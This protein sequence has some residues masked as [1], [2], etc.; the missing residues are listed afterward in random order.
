V[1]GL[2][3]IGVKPTNLAFGLEARRETYGITAGELASYNNGMQGAP[4]AG[5]GAQ[6]FP[7]F[8]RATKSMKIARPSASM[9][10]S[11]RR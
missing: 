9:P 8:S 2:D 5:L 1:R 4:G 11:R 7:G 10:T 6:G 3:W